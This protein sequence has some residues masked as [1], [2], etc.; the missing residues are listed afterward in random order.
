M[1]ETPAMIRQQMEQTKLQLAEKLES[2]ERQVST[3]VHTTETALNATMET[4]ETVSG[5]VHGT[6]NS[7]ANLLDVTRHV[8]NHPWLIVG[9][10]VLA[11]YLTAEFFTGETSEAVS[12]SGT[13]TYSAADELNGQPV[14]TPRAHPALISVR[15]SSGTASSSWDQFQDAAIGSLIEIVPQTISRIIPRVVDRLIDIWSQ[16]AIDSS[17][18]SA[19]PETAAEP[20]PVES[21]RLRIAKSGTGGCD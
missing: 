11:G 8:E 5:A 19:E 21:H 10:A 15:H 12:N 1:N 3:T 20:S 16:P 9:G 4:V 17:S 2:L 13:T 18:I 7:I 14:T 6:V